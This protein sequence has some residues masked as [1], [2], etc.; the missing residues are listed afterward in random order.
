MRCDTNE[1]MVIFQGYRAR[2]E[3]RSMRKKQT[4]NLKTM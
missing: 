3:P 2:N 1:S 4:V